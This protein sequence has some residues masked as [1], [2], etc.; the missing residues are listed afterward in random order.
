M[1]GWTVQTYL[2]VP[3]LS[4]VAV[5]VSPLL[6]SW[7][8]NASFSATASCW[9][10]SS[11]TQQTCWPVLTVAVSGS[12]LMSAILIVTASLGQD[13]DALEPPS[14]SESPPQPASTTKAMIS[15]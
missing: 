7:D 8:L 11:L 2:I 1:P 3:G 15:A 12:N 5:N 10:S 4:S 9:T 13:E 14:P 6:N